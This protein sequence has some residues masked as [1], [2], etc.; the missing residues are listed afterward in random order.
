MK[1]F[2][3]L[4]TFAEYGQK[5]LELLKK[6]GLQFTINPTGRRLTGE[7]VA[8]YA[9]D[10]QGIVA[11]V[12]LYTAEV[13]T[14][15]PDLKCISRC[16]VGVDNIDLKKA[17]DL[18]I[19]ICNTPD[20]VIQPV[21]ELTVGMILDLLRNITWHT[22]SLKARKWQKKGG[23]NLRGSKVGIIGLGRI[24]KRVAELLMTLGAEV[25]GSDPR[26]DL[27]WAQK[28][29]VNI[30][31]LRELLSSSDIISLHVSSLEGEPFGFGE[32]EIGQM[33]K[34]AFL[35]NLSRGELVDENALYGALKSGHLAGAGLD[36]FPQEPYT[37]KLCDLENV[38]M[39]PHAATLTMESRVEM[40]TAAVE[41]LLNVLQREA[42]VS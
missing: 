10:S 11:G 1:V 15:L 16:G 2:V 35:I 13:L 17:K 9:Q 28:T 31:A 27:A 26:P 23:R 3:A 22:A 14:K 29:K 4:S 38:I 24:G 12:E 41:N 39:T 19:Q 30:V 36:V 21:A 25:S 33:K 34:G 40:E 8:E 18:G 7:E 5:P 20:P 42:V 37:G 32:K 6:S